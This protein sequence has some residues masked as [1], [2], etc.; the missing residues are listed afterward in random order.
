M[1]CMVNIVVVVVYFIESCL[2]IMEELSLDKFSLF[3][4]LGVYNL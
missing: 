2:K 1:L 4:F 3:V